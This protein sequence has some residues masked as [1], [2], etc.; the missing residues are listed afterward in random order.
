M[1]SAMQ[2]TNAPPAA[3]A[4]TSLRGPGARDDDTSKNN[5]KPLRRTAA[6]GST[7]FNAQLIRRFRSTVGA[8]SRDSPPLFSIV[9]IELVMLIK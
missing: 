6:I 4:I 3:T 7:A 2:T 5:N 1:I 8:T 9:R